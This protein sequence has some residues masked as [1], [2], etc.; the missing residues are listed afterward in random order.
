MEVQVTDQFVLLVTAADLPQ[1]DIWGRALRAAGIECQVIA[2]FHHAG[3]I[4][5]TSLQAEIWVKRQHLTP[6]QTVMR[7]CRLTQDDA[8]DCNQKNDDRSLLRLLVDQ[9]R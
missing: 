6:A 7:E 3:A 1:A 4:C 8:Q 9:G 5:L 2:D